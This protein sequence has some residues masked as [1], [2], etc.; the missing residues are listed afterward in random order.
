MMRRLHAVTATVTQLPGGN[1]VAVGQPNQHPGL[2]V[3]SRSPLRN[4]TGGPFLP[5]IMAPFPTATV[6]LIAD[7]GQATRVR[8][9]CTTGAQPAYNKQR[10]D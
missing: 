2:R 8:N 6:T 3:M 7:C 9:T 5:A 1:K 4:R 10:E